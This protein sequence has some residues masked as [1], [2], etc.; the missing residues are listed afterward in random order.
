MTESLHQFRL[1]HKLLNHSRVLTGQCLHRHWYLTLETCN[2]LWRAS[3]A[4]TSYYH[5]LVKALPKYSIVQPQ[6]YLF[7]CA[8]LIVHMTYYAVVS[9]NRRETIASHLH[10]VELTSH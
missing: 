3:R 9:E 4:M 2:V 6:C 5:T 10:N 7:L 8:N 1:L